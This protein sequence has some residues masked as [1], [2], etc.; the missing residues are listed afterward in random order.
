M[1]YFLRCLLVKDYLKSIRKFADYPVS[2]SGFSYRFSRVPQLNITFDPYNFSEIVEDCDT[3]TKSR[4][5]MQWVADNTAYNG[6]SP[7]GPALPDKIVEFG[8]HQKN[9]INCANRAILFCDILT[10]LGIFSYPITL[11]HRPY[12][13]SKKQFSNECHCHVIAQVWLTERACWAAFDP[14][15]NTFFVDKKGVNV[16]IAK[17]VQMARTKQRII[18]IDNKTNELSNNGLLCAYVGLL[19]ISVSVGNGFTER[20]GQENQV[21][22]LPKSYV[23]LIERVAFADDKWSQ[24]NSTIVNSVKISLADIDK[25]PKWI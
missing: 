13:F 8:I 19:D 4:R 11:Q 24:H 16:G 10:S 14:T 21:H 22:L 7:L 9:P 2:D 15:F 17:M 5:I 20:N 18:S 12:L 6:G 25:A 1:N 3:L 23:R